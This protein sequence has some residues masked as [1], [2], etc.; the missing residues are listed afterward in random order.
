MENMTKG[1]MEA[2]IS[3][4][5]IKFEM[6]FMGR[7]PRETVSYIINSAK[8]WYCFFSNSKRLSKSPFM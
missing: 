1:Q 3:E 8:R 6:E 4:E 5:L 2:K 7:G